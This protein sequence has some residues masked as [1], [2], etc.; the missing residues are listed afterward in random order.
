MNYD[1][2]QHT[3]G[4]LLEEIE[5]LRI[6]GQDSIEFDPLTYA[7]IRMHFDPEG[8]HKEKMQSIILTLQTA[9]KL[10]E[11]VIEKRKEKHER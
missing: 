10:I 6:K 7:I 9:K 11:S 2:T 3:F 8:W 1:A 4:C 5:E